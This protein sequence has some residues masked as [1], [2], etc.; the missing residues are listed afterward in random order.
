[1]EEVVDVTTSPGINNGTGTGDA[2]S[3]YT[4]LIGWQYADRA[5]KVM[6]DFMNANSDP[7]E[8]AIFEPGASANGAYIGLDPSLTSSAQT[9]ILDG[10]TIAR[11]NRSTLSQN[12]KLPGTL[13]TAA[14]TELSLAEYYL[15]AGMDANA[16]TAYEAGITQSINYYYWLRTFS[17]N[18][19]SGPLTPLA[20]GEID[21]Y[22]AE[23]G[24]AW[25][26]AATTAEKLNRIA[27]QKWIN[28]NVMSPM[29][30]WAEFRRLDLPVL[31][32]VP[33]AA[34]QQLPPKRWQYSGNEL[35]FNADNYAAVQA[36]DRLDT[37]I[38]WDVK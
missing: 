17:D 30:T 13:I 12:I 20:P 26:T 32:F 19:V 7:R 36:K 2:A 8:R 4:G 9:N 25:S 5:G 28:S 24:V 33:D 35:T 22:L 31:S 37:K 29:E 16:K 18:S 6:I 11:Y 15:N 27:T 3:F 10:G 14:E 1:V 21:N 23:P 34:A 38:F